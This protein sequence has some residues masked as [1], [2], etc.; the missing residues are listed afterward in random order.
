MNELPILYEKIYLIAQILLTLVALKALS[1]GSDYSI[2]K[3]IKYGKKY[4]IVYKY[5][6]IFFHEKSMDEIM[7]GLKVEIK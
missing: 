3:H 5:R 2:Y 6:E 4:W 7:K 1:I